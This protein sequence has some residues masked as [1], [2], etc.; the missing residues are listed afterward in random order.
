MRLKLLEAN[1]MPSLAEMETFAKRFRAISQT[2]IPSLTFAAKP[3]A[4]VPDEQL[5]SK[6]DILRDTLTQLTA[7]HE[8]LAAAVSAPAPKLSHQPLTRRFA[9]QRLQDSIGGG[10]QPQTRPN[11]RPRSNQ[12][13]RCF[14]CNGLGHFARSCPYAA[15]CTLCLGWGHEQHQCANNSSLSGKSLN[16]KGV[17]Q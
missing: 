13:R 17:L 1:P 4:E 3:A 2:N 10:F 14:N 5:A 11:N 15:Q 9:S 7:R 8:H 12:G 16:F 6:F